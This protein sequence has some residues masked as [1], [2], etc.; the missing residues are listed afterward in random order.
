MRECPHR[1]VPK[2]DCPHLDFALPAADFSA[3]ARARFSVRDFRPDPIPE[4]LLGAILDDA[5]YA[6]SWSNTRPYCLAV[7]SGERRDRLSAAY[8]KAYESALPL[9]RREPLALA[10]AIMTRS[11]PD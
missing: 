5:R 6:P 8:V 1:S 9:R 11:L 10:K 7:A 4:A 3:L 2:R